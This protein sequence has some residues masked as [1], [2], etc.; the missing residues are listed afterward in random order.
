[1]AAIKG[2]LHSTCSICGHV[3]PV[4]YST[5]KANTLNRANA[6]IMRRATDRVQEWFT[7]A[8]GWGTRKRKPGRG[9]MIR[10]EAV[11]RVY[12]TGAGKFL[13]AIYRRAKKEAQDANGNGTWFAVGTHGGSAIGEQYFACEL[14]QLPTVLR[15]LASESR[16]FQQMLLRSAG[17]VSGVNLENPGDR[18]DD[19]PDFIDPAGAT[20]I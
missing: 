4:D 11:A 17:V 14:E 8:W 3:Q 15:A 1:L 12:V 10:S 6:Q 7:N 5:A 9:G 19:P 13:R 2:G 20:F 18:R 16:E